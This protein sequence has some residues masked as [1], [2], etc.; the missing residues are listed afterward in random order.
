MQEL[1]CRIVY[2][3]ANGKIILIHH[4]IIAPRAAAPSDSDIETHAMNLATKSTGRTP[5]EFEILST[6]PSNLRHGF[7][8]SV[9]VTKKEL[10][11]VPRKKK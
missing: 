7:D 3:K 10:R 6:D 11:V 1:A 5:P 8:Q 4:T 9:D 2:D